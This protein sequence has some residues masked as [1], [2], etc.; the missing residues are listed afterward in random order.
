MG[1]AFR[2]THRACPAKLPL[3]R[4]HV[5]AQGKPFD[6]PAYG[7]QVFD[8]PGT[9]G[10]SRQMPLADERIRRVQLS[11]EKSVQS[12]PPFRA[13]SKPASTARGR[14]KRLRYGHVHQVTER[15]RRLATFVDAGLAENLLR[16]D[17]SHFKPLLGL[18]LRQLNNLAL[19]E[20]LTSL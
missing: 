6:L 17:Q 20:R 5:P 2:S 12:E 13:S 9:T 3:Q 18:L 8:F 16:F 4:G 1:I 14:R 11:I 15:E 19:H 10:A 7:F